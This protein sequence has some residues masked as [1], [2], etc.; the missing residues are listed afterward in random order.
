MPSPTEVDY[1]TADKRT[2]ERLIRNGIVDARAVSK[3]LK[4]LPDVADKAVAAEASV[5]VDDADGETDEG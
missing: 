2:L 3:A 4:A 1:T 5:L